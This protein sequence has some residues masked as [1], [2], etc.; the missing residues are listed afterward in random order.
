MNKWETLKE[1][2]NSKEVGSIITRK[3][4]IKFNKYRRTS[5]YG[6]TIDNYRRCL[7][8]LGIL[9]YEDRGKYIVKHHIRK[10][11]TSSELKSIAYGGFREWFNDAK[12]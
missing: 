8:I 5:S 2:I 12:A 9:G 7:K 6:T 1:Y 10:D 3:D 4:I 11:L